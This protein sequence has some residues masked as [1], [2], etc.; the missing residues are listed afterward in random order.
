M[1]NTKQIRMTWHK[2]KLEWA[3]QVGTGNNRTYTILE[4]IFW[5]GTKNKKQ[6]KKQ[7][8]KKKKIYTGQ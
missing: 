8:K 5:P 3:T 7:K 1:I 4:R 2:V 6:K